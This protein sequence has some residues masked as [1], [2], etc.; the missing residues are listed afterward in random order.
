M[1]NSIGWVSKLGRRKLGRV[2]KTRATK[3]AFAFSSQQ[4]LGAECI[5]GRSEDIFLYLQDFLNDKTWGN[6][7][8]LPRCTAYVFL[9]LC[10]VELLEQW[11]PACMDFSCVIVCMDKVQFICYRYCIRLWS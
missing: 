4:D 5:S 3:N 2:D 10:M 8:V 1:I 6:V 11:E 7:I 9:I